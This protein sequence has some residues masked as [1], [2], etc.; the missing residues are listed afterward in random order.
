M[1]KID[2]KNNNDQ[3]AVQNDKY[4]DVVIVTSLFLWIFVHPTYGRTE[5]TAKSARQPARIAT[6]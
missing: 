6:E 1:A 5:E 2:E 3:Y 4:Q